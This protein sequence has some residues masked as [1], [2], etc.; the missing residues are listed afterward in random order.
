MPISTARYLG[1]L[2]IECTH[3]QSGGKILVDAPTDNHGKGEAF[4]PTDLFC[5]SLACC[6]MNII[7]VYAQENGLDV[8]GMTAEIS[9]SMA[10]NPRR[11]GGIEVVINMPDQEY[12][13]WNKMNMESSIRKCPVGLSLHPEI[14][15]DVRIVW[16]RQ[17]G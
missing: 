2:S 10:Q 4:S 14:R 12:S 13:Q 11:V 3:L 1:D 7:G 16:A 5:T 8:S 15:L 9:K 17:P 6:A